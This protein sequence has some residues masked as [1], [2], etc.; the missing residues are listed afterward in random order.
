[1]KLTY[2]AVFW[3]SFSFINVAAAEPACWRRR[4]RESMCAPHECTSCGGVRVQLMN[5]HRPINP[6]P[7]LLYGSNTM[8]TYATA[9]S[10]LCIH[11]RWYLA[12]SPPWSSMI[13]L[14]RENEMILHFSCI[15]YCSRLR[16]NLML[17]W[18]IIVWE[19][20]ALESR[21]S[22]SRGRFENVIWI[23]KRKRRWYKWFVGI[24]FLFIKSCCAELTFLYFYLICFWSNRCFRLF[25]ILSRF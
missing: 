3:A 8:C 15:L 14:K 23:F 25:D 20:F 2:S 19:N 11:G 9:L 17:L 21:W 12:W 24:Y 5:W 4:R 13:R 6:K 18:M 22:L 1:M 16:S 7:G 10:L